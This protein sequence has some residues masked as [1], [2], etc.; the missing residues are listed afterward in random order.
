MIGSSK[1]ACAAHGHALKPG[2]VRLSGIHVKKDQI[3]SK[4][5]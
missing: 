4:E 1:V 2:E 3:M 5:I